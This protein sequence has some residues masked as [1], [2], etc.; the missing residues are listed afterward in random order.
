[1]ETQ[2]AKLRWRCHRGMLELDLILIPF[3]DTCFDALSQENKQHFE[4]LLTYP[5]PELYALLLG[6]QTMD[7]ESLKPLVELIKRH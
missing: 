4:H 1:M 3:F 2:K 7:D 6:A 5:D